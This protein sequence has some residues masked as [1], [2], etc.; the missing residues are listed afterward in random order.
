MN[1]LIRQKLALAAQDIQVREIL[2]FIYRDQPQGA[3]FESLKE[4]LF[5]Q[6]Q[7]EETRLSDLVS[8]RVLIFDGS[9][10]RVSPEAR[11]VLDRD[12]VILMDEFMRDSMDEE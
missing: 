4:T 7:F 9:R 11:Q 10:Y 5:L 6:D 1:P 2:T 3:S 8:G 12:P